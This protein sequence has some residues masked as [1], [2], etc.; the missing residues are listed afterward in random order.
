MV[1]DD[2]ISTSFPGSGDMKLR[3]VA[4]SVAGFQPSL[5]LIDLPVQINVQYNNLLLAREFV[6]LHFK[7]SMAS[8]Y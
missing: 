3:G 8:A 5:P 2:R 6:S 1:R 4:V 7:S